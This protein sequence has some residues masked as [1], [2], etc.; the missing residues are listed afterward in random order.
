MLTAILLD[1]LAD[2]RGITRQYLESNLEAHSGE[3]HTTHFQEPGGRG[4][5]VRDLTGGH[6]KLGATGSLL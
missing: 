4:L 5:R 3:L 2:V 6:S 1:L